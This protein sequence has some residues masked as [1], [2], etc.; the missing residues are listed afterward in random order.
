MSFQAKSSSQSKQIL[1]PKLPLPDVSPKQTL[2]PKQPLLDVSLDDT[3]SIAGPSTRT[4]LEC[5]PG[6]EPGKYAL[7]LLDALFTDEEMKGNLFIKSQ[8][9]RSTRGLLPQ[10]KVKKILCK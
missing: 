4:N 2:Q 8:R 9:S 1:K 10:D 5:L 7:N 3:S 6:S